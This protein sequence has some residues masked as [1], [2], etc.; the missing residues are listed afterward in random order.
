MGNNIKIIIKNI[1][2]IIFVLG[3]IIFLIFIHNNVNENNNDVIKGWLSNKDGTFY[4]DLNDGKLIENII[5][6]AIIKIYYV[7]FSMEEQQ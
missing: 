6:V 1:L 7:C 4:Y 3:I 2:S 5:V